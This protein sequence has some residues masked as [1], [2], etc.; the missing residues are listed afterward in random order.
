MVRH[1]NLHKYYVDF[2]GNDKNRAQEVYTGIHDTSTIPLNDQFEVT[3]DEEDN[4]FPP[5]ERSRSVSKKKL[6]KS[7]STKT[8][9]N[10]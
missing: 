5:I 2:S 1:I 6:V 7:Y 4:E 3:Y 10:L 9:K 8:L